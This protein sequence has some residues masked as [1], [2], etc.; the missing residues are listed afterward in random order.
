M[1]R[2]FCF[3]RY[4]FLLSLCFFVATPARAASTGQILGTVVDAKTKAPIAG[5]TI[6][7]VSPS[8]AYKTVTDSKGAFAIAGVVLDTYTISVQIKG[9]TSFLLEGQT[10]TADEGTRLTVELEHEL[11]T[12]AQL[13]ARGVGSAFQPSQTVD[14]YTITSA[15]IDQL[16]GKSFDVD[17]T[18]LL[19]KLPSVTVDRSGDPLIRGGF[20]FQTQTQVD[21]IDYTIPAR[22]LTNRSQNVGNLNTLNGINS[23]ELIPGGGDATHGDTGTGLIAYTIKRGTYPAHT[24]FDYELGLVG[25]AHQFSFDDARTFGERHQLSNYFSLVSVDAYD[26]Y[27]PYGVDS[28]SIGA[29]AITPDPNANSN[30]NAHTGSLYTTAFYNTSAAQTRDYLDNLVFRFGK[31][32]RQSLQFFIQQQIVREPQ[33]YGGFGSLTYPLVGQNGSVI[34]ELVGQGP[35]SNPA[36]TSLV[37]SHVYQQYPGSTPGAYLTGPD[38]AYNPFEAF[39]IEYQNSLNDSTSLGIRYYRTFSNQQEFQPDQG[40]FAP[41]NGGTRTSI[42]ADL[43]KIDGTKHTF[44][45][46]GKFEFT[47]PYGTTNDYID[48]LPA[49]GDVAAPDAQIATINPVTVVPDFVTPSA[50]TPGCRGTPFAPASGSASGSFLCG[51]LTKFFANGA[52]PALPPETEIPTAKQQTYSL[53]AQDTYAPNKLTKVLLGVRLDGYNFLIP[54]D[55]ENPPAVDGVR[56]QR[57]VEPH[58]GLSQL[59][60]KRD[61]VRLNYGRTLSIPLPTFL[62]ENIDRSSF[63]AFNGVPSYDNTKG[64]FDPARPLATQATYCGPGVP[65]IA[66]DQQVVLGNQPCQSYADQL[67]WLVRNYRFG[68]QSQITYPLRGA[69]FS[70][71]D[72]SYSHE[73][74]DQTALKVTPFYR[75]GYDIVETTRTLLGYDP[76]TEV[77][78]LSPEINANLGIQEATGI[79]LDVTKQRDFGIGY[80]FT[81]TYINQVG[82]DPPGQYL[83][84]PSLQLGELYRSPNLS[85]LQATFGLTY[86]THFGLKIN[87]VVSYKYG[88]P[89]GDG[90]YEAIDYN[91][92]AVYLPLTDALVEG[93]QAALISNAYVNPQN[94]GTVTN[95]NIVASRGTEGL[96]TGP[97]TLRSKAT[98]NTDVT[99]ELTAPGSKLTYGVG[100]TN[101]FDQTADIPVTNLTDVFFPVSSGNFFYTGTLTNSNGSH[102]QPASVGSSR[103]AYIVFPNQD[104]FA[105][106]FYIQAKL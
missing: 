62:G 41:L 18:K 48:Y 92:N 64:P 72:L 9:Y 26:Q 77:A 65:A 100:I 66:N 14:R 75:R 30:I 103:Q 95:P 47:V 82:N 33:N 79:E 36:E 28:R 24:S 84:T 3:V 69:T 78:N 49:Y 98:L 105:L 52:V 90:I 94:P 23:L 10:V 63:D 27:G 40:L 43:T 85:P 61:S 44:Q 97:G 38:T 71:Y 59:F 55:P 34:A 50:S 46:G 37:A 70:N 60:G 57:L 58:L 53:Y 25:D 106:R 12:I 29:S 20:S 104:P 1:A 6:N 15:G 83:P 54:D 7:A 13:H 17:G 74:P 22:S 89:Y 51:Y 101:L 80:Q 39:K 86:R 102:T 87:P 11:R 19:S 81:A 35:N 2:R 16:Q 68:Q 56:H 5:A 76:T 93:T 91:G 42:G 45:V 73:F 88:Y 67:Y 31:A 96:N 99:I 21:G 8:Q 32:A 4:C